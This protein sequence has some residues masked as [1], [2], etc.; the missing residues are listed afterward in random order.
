MTCQG[1]TVKVL[2]LLVM[3][4]GPWEPLSWAALDLYSSD[5]VC[6]DPGGAAAAPPGVPL[7]INGRLRSLNSQL[8]SQSRD[9]R[10]SRPDLLESF[11][12]AGGLIDVP[13]TKQNCAQGRITTSV[14]FTTSV[15][16]SCDI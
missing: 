5:D 15:S 8:K 12:V 4:Q 16:V 13:E 2:L 1:N 10:A 11:H 7:R 6:Q 14:E 9:Q 3:K